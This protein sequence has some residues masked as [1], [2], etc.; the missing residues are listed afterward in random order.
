MGATFHWLVTENPCVTWPCQQSAE[1]GEPTIMGR[2]PEVK[3]AQRSDKVLITIDLPD[4]KDPKVK[5]EPEGKFCFSATGYELDLDL[6]EK[7][8]I[9][10]SKTS[11]GLRNVFC[12]LVK[13]EKGWWKRLLKGEGKSPPYLK[14]DWDK[15]VDEDEED[16][17]K[18]EFDNFDLGSMGGFPGFNPSG[19][20]GEDEPDSDDE[21]VS[22]PPAESQAKS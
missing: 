19:D 6:F 14:V 4:A 8:N 9:E 17:T 10:E 1:E 21:D 20:M 16:V 11:I 2:H 7:I 3:W 12:A 13:S 15:W 22:V 5:I 18:N